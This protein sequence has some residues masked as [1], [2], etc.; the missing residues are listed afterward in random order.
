MNRHLS[1]QE[2]FLL[3]CL[4]DKTGKFEGHTLLY[5][6][7]AAALAELML[8]QR[9]TYENGCVQVKRM[10]HTGDELLDVALNQIAFQPSKELTWWV[11]Y[12]YQDRLNP[13]DVLIASLIR[14]NILTIEKGQF[15]WMPSRHNVYP[16]ADSPQRHLRRSLQEAVSSESEVDGRTSVL[17]SLLHHC[18]LL[19]LLL[20]K[21]EIKKYKSRIQS[22]WQEDPIAAAVGRAVQ[23]A[24]E[25]DAAVTAEASAMTAHS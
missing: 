9:I 15:L 13:E 3:L 16:I 14:R 17:I 23:S 8:S 25:E 6:L 2:Q 24:I 12:L 11:R 21:G 5:G 1:L 18:R 4:N 10:A 19:S 7:N 20:T 22:L